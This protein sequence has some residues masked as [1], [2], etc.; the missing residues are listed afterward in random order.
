MKKKF[1]S[2]VEKFVGLIRICVFVSQKNVAL[3]TVSYYSILGS[4]SF[5]F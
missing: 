2:E 5:S 3:M 1:S 4:G